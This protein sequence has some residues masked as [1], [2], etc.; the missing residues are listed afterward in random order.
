MKKIKLKIILTGGLAA[1]VMLYACKKSF[2]EKAPL[3]T[4]NEGTLANNA[5]VQGLLIGAYSAL[6]GAGVAG[7]GFYSSPT[8]WAFGGVA[9]DDAYKGSDAGDQGNEV[10]P[11]ETYTVTSTNSPVANKWAAVYDGVTRCN[12]VLRIMAKA[13]DMADSDKVNVEAQVRFLRGHYHFEAKKIFNKV[14]F[15]DETITY[16]A[17]NYNVPNSSDIWPN[18]EADFKFAVDNLR[19]TQEAIGRA[20]KSAAKAYLAKVYMYQQ[21]YAEAKP[22]LEDVIANGKNSLGKNFDL[23]NFADNFNAETDNNAESIFAVQ[24]SVNDG[25]Q[26][27]KSNVGDVLNFPYNNG[28]NDM[29]GG[30]CGFYQPTQNLVNAYRVD[31]D[32]LPFLTTFNDVPVKNDQGLKS[33]DPF[34]PETAPLDSRLDWTVGRRGIPYLDW[35]LHPGLRWIRDQSNGGPYSPK[36]HVYYKR[37]EGKFTD[38]SYW[39]KGVVA[40]NYIILRFADVLLWDAEVEVEIGSLDK[41]KDLVNRVRARAADPAGWVKKDDGTPAAN[42]KVG[43]YTAFPSQEYARTAVRF[44]RRLELAMEGHRFFDLVRWGIAAETLN[45]YVAKEKTLRS[46]LGNA[47]FTKGKNE[48]FPIPQGEIDLTQ[49]ALVQNPG[50]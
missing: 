42:Y 22:L 37:Q 29:P 48:Y 13:T 5:G 12:D 17:G 2:L 7:S 49:G 3:G 8:N 4:L 1:M 38:N 19:E 16:V 11:I 20:N 26:G 46:Y 40:T 6:N 27:N 43:L 45:A 28:E 14:P 31:A 34:T 18:I 24:H 44:E 30:C 9:S 23:V 47:N 32:G 50:Y 41:A 25:S 15:V 10:N 33:T 39:T 36:K 21:K 35:G